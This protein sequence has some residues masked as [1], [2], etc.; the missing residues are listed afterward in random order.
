MTSR[1]FAVLVL[2]A[3]CSG[4]SVADGPDAPATDPDAAVVVEPGFT[5][6][7][8]A[9]YRT[10]L[11]ATTETTIDHAWAN[12]EPVA[13]AGADHFSARFT[14]TL[15]AETAGTY[16]FATNADDGVRLWINDTL[17][18][19]NWVP[20]FP[21]RHAG[22][23]DLPAGPAALRLEYFEADLGAELHLSW[24]PPGGTEAVLDA[25]HVHTAAPIEGAPKPPYAN[26]VVPTNCPDPGVLA[27]GDAFYALCTGG[28]FPIHK[29]YDLVMWEDTGKVVIP[30]GKP[31]WAAN[32]GRNWAP[33]MHEVNGQYLVYYTSV[34]AAN[35]LSIGVAHAD[36][37]TG[38]FI[39]RGSPLVQDPLGVIDAS[40]VKAGA[41]HYLVYKID[42]NSQGKPTPIYIRELA[43][44]GL[45]FAAGSTAK[46][47]L[48]NDPAT[49]EGGV[50][51]GPW[52]TEH[53]G[54]FY[55]FYSGNVYD[56][57]YRTGVA[58]AASVTGP[59][60]KL[61]TPILKNDAQWVGPG[62][63][64]VVSVGTK[65]Y[66]VYHAWHNNG[67]GGNDTTRGRNILVDEITY[68][69]GWPKIN[70]GT[71]SSGLLPWPGTP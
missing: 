54:M 10:P 45:S 50:V 31:S 5:A 7:Y 18:I 47:I 30:S 71:P 38:T 60:T 41:T 61:G 51:E 48:R 16:G 68:A 24:T 57:R 19:D 37:P 29:S 43:P 65:D 62:H 12:G 36:S 52:I 44:D 56:S 34:N 63:G 39:D 40:Y 32:G 22:T 8:F 9:S 21:E 26:P 27:V 33:E 66:F 58:R 35:V 1:S 4:S 23:I 55:L 11:T 46:E 70:D 53:A 20:H 42:G 49:W 6:Q 64:S 25:A 69:N 2:A 28:K 13:G 59:Y 3:G 14:A 67:S 17:V 15:D